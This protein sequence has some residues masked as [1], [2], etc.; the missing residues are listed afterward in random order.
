MIRFFDLISYFELMMYLASD[1]QTQSVYQH[2][3]SLSRYFI[4]DHF[5]MLALVQLYFWVKQE[6]EH[7]HDDE[8]PGWI[9][10]NTNE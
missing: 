9:R 7:H 10:K 5:F 8:H 4:Y 1:G 3:L 6:P 2:S